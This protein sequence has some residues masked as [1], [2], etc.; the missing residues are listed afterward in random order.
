MVYLVISVAFWVIEMI[1]WHPSFF[2]A[3]F[4]R[5]G[6][7]AMVTDEDLSDFEVGETVLFEARGNLG[8][9]PWVICMTCANC[10]FSWD[11]SGWLGKSRKTGKTKHL[12]IW[13]E[14]CPGWLFFTAL[15][16]RMGWSVHLLAWIWRAKLFQWCHDFDIRCLSTTF[17]KGPN[18]KIK[19]GLLKIVNIICSYWTS[20]RWITSAV[21]GDYT[22]GRHDCFFII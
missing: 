17:S 13:F 10:F 6:C 19:D 20:L 1:V 14:Q 15:L 3:F 16:Q 4:T 12:D 5:C 22:G 11:G 9:W 18:T 21:S 2:F 7:D 8:G